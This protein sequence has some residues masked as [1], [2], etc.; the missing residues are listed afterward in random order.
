VVL[1]ATRHSGAVST[2]FVLTLISAAVV[3][4]LIVL[5]LDPVIDLLLIIE[6]GVQAEYALALLGFVLSFA[7]LATLALPIGS[8]FCLTAGYLFGTVQGAMAALIGGLLAASLT[9]FLARHLVGRRRIEQWRGGR[10]R[11]ESLLQALERDAGWYLVLLRIVPIAP[12]FLVNASAGLTRIRPGP[13]HLASIIGLIPTTLIYAA[14][15][16]GIG[17]LVE[18]QS[19][20]GSASLL[21][22]EVAGPLAALAVLLVSGLAVKKRL[23]QR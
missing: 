1:N 10:G 3:T 23:G 9:F 14:L 11:I 7:V 21:R 2:G 17:S 15:G 18:A 20:M 5:G 19:L 16:N 4:S 6:E 8:L 13:Y 22:M 12:F